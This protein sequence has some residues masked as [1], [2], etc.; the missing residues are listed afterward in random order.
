M[1]T[2]TPESLILTKD[3]KHER[4][5]SIRSAWLERLRGPNDSSE[6]IGEYNR[7]KVRA[8]IKNRAQINGYYI[9]YG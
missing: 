7:Q 5:P 9:S 6:R 1:P 8:A 3:G 2:G 4:F